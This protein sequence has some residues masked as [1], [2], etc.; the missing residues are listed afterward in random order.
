LLAPKK[1]EVLYVPWEF[2]VPFALDAACKGVSTE[3]EIRS[4]NLAVALRLTA[5]LG[6]L[7]LK[8]VI[9]DPLR[10]SS[11][12]LELIA[13]KQFGVAAASVPIGRMRSDEI[14]PPHV[15]EY[16]PEPTLYGEAIALAHVLTVVER[17]AVV[18]VPNSL[19]FRTA[20]REKVF[21]GKLV[22]SGL[23]ETVLTVPPRAWTSSGAAFS[24][25]VLDK[26]RN[27]KDV[28]FVQASS[29]DFI[30]E[31]QAAP[32]RGVPVEI[33]WQRIIK[34]VAER[35]TTTH[36]YLAMVDEISKNEF[37]LEPGRY[38]Q[39]GAISL[40]SAFDDS[41]E[42]VS[43]EDI[44]E[45]IRPLSNRAQDGA[46][47]ECLEVGVADIDKD[48]TIR[49]PDK[50][51][52]LSTKD[53]QRHL[54][55]A[56]DILVVAKGSAGKVAMVTDDIT[57]PLVANQSFLVVRINPSSGIKPEALLRY[58]ASPRVQACMRGLV[59]GTAIPMLQ[60]RDLAKLA[61]PKLASQEQDRICSTQQELRRLSN[62]LRTLEGAIQ[63]LKLRHWDQPK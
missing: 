38:V 25:L 28:L 34:I 62:E 60:V 31:N 6:N 14:L 5:E 50:M 33:D 44:A 35:S 3:V 19:L 16:L 47:F 27:S 1:G 4:Q 29:D 51:V 10:G 22:H 59:S 9:S 26:Q 7:P 40:S 21:K 20:G 37:N 32:R 36:S 53:K 23:I 58:L 39:S 46:E 45:L 52:A 15:L 61:V 55:R 57:Q 2:S 11:G 17:R 18:I 8:V 42:M 54:L 63:E 49:S 12:Q 30:L 48:D 56:G 41:V 43:L 24:L 13:R